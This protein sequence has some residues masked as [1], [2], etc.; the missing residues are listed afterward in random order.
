MGAEGLG[1][2][3]RREREIRE[4][5]AAIIRCLVLEGTGCHLKYFIPCCNPLSIE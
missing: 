2:Q 4:G 3:G 1:E 5:G